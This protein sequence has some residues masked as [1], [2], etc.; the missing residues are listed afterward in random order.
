MIDKHPQLKKDVFIRGFLFTNKN[1]ADLSS[2][3]FY[4]NWNEYSFGP[5][6][7][8]W[9]NLT[10]FNY[11]ETEDC[12]Y[13]ILGHAYNP[14]NMQY[15]EAQILKD[16]S[17]CNT[18][19]QWLE[20]IHDLTGIFII[21]KIIDNN[22][23]F[24]CDPAG[25]QSCFW[26]I[27]DDY[28]YFSSHSQL[29]ADICNL[30]QDPF[31]GQLI[32]YKWYNRILGPYLPADLSPYEKIKR[33]I[34]GFLY[35]SNLKDIS[36]NRFWPVKHIE[37]KNYSQVINDASKILSNN[38]I[39]VSKKWQN[40]AISLTGGIDSNTTF[41][42]A[43]GIYKK[44]S[45]FTYVSADKEIPDAQAAR[46][47][48]EKFA[49]AH[50]QYD[51]PDKNND[52]NLFEERKQLFLHN[53]GYIGFLS[54]YE[55]R[56]KLYLRDF[57]NCSVEVKSWVSE[58]TRCYWNKYYNRKRFPKLSPKLFRNFYKIFICNR[59]LAHKIDSIYSKYF[60]NYCYDLISDKVLPADIN[61]HE[62]GWG[63]WGGLNI[64]EMKYCFDITCIY[65]N[66][67][68]LDLMFDVAFDKRFN[69][70]HH[71]DMKKILNKEL[72]D[73]NIR[74]KNVKETKFR[75]FALNILFTLNSILPF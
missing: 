41:A 55:L 24:L 26:S 60:K 67:R 47:I 51:I 34:S 70:Q 14:F 38:M 23:T 45:S 54:D 27:L 2:F 62:I 59:S 68:F 3:P 72:Y 69:D 66:R 57:C 73:M 32:N 46:I 22:I 74:I 7:F 10:N 16:L 18:Q 11:L 40:P 15:L 28:V 50:K 52:I 43:N 25:L 13:F 8:Y 33:I 49:V 29:I 56:K 71:L 58:S 64:T 63:S 1:I 53:N 36:F 31:V 19:D 9:H 4:G 35:T 65:N 61:Y 6:N 12:L 37:N 5:F 21:G 42:A 44:F 75:A 20:Y 39:L 30:K 17:T 48:S